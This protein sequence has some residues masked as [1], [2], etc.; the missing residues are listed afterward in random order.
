M[1]GFL[2]LTF[3]SPRFFKSFWFLVAVDYSAVVD[4][5]F[6]NFV[7]HEGPPPPYPA[8]TLPICVCVCTHTRNTH[9]RTFVCS[10]ILLQYFQLPDISRCIHNFLRYFK[11][12]MYLSYF[13][14][15]PQT[16]FCGSIT[17]RGTLFETRYRRQWSCL[18]ANDVALRTSPTATARLICNHAEIYLSSVV[19]M[20]V[21]EH[22]WHKGCVCLF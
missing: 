18:T 19:F 9:T 16:V 8:E 2:I 20:C 1:C 21:Q 13:F 12:V 7:F 5:C 14:W 6:S 11:I 22:M 15:E 3:V 17:F 4:Q 10:R